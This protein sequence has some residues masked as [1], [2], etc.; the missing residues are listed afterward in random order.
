VK[1]TKLH[2]LDSSWSLA[3][4]LSGWPTHSILKSSFNVVFTITFLFFFLT[5]ILYLSVCTGFL[6]LHQTDRIQQK[7]W[8]AT[9]ETR[10]D[11]GFCFFLFS[12]LVSSPSPCLREDS[13]ELH[14]ERRQG[15]E[16][17]SLESE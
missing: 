10:S 11:C 5:F 4:V 7:Q 14:V 15:K 1:L 2:T 6:G 8:N 9:C 17:M 13:G 3:P 12:S 16:L